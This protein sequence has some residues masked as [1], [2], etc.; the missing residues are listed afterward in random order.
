MDNQLVAF[1]P[2][3]IERELYLIGFR[4]DP[5]AEGAQFYTLIGSEGDGERPITRGGRLL[6]FRTPAMAGKALAAS[7]NGFGD[8]GPAPEELELLCD[9]GEALHVANQEDEDGEGALFELIAVFDDL[10]REIKLTVPGEYTAV[11]AAMAERL[12]ES[13]EFASFLASGEI[14]R[15]RLEDAL[16][17]CVGAVAA[18]SSWV[19]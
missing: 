18:K 3:K 12:G 10:L 16:L 19:E 2:K 14:A 11:L 17:W 15:E 8:A 9:I 5:G 1:P 6:F 13:V 4:I 7:D